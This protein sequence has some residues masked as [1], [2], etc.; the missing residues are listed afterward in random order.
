MFL[1][2]A[3]KGFQSALRAPLC[4][5]RLLSSAPA[6]APPRDAVLA[7]FRAIVG[8]ANVLD[9]ADA[10]PVKTAS[11]LKG[12]RLGHGRAPA[13]ALPTR[14]GQVPRLVEAAVDAGCAVVVQGTN[15]GNTR[16]VCFSKRFDYVR[17]SKQLFA[18]LILQ[19]SPGLTG[20]SVP[21]GDG[22]DRPAVVISTRRLN[23]ILPVDHGERVLCLAGVGLGSLKNFVAQHFPGRQSHSTLGSNFLNPTTA[24]GEWSLDNRLR[25]SLSVQSWTNRSDCFFFSNKHHGI[26]SWLIL[27]LELLRTI[28]AIDTENI[29]YVSHLHSLLL[30]TFSSL[31]RLDVI[32]ASRSARA[33]LRF[34]RGH[35]PLKGPYT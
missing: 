21:R 1:V 19:I 6:A 25:C 27:R 14:L 4:A 9:P 8:T 34:A 16:G 29:K 3:R 11:Y 18:H 12:Q 23:A 20:G 31:N 24:A 7:S 26:E 17:C 35:P 5:R 32:Q 2:S 10:P 15:T 33:V 30:S 13:I 28:T 22:D